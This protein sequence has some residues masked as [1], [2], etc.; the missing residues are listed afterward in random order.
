MHTLERTLYA[1][2]EARHQAARKSA[3][4][5]VN[6]QGGK[7]VYKLLMR[8]PSGPKIA[9]VGDDKADGGEPVTV[10]LSNFITL[11]GEGGN[12]PTATW[13]ASASPDED[14]DDTGGHGSDNMTR[15]VL[16]VRNSRILETM[17][18]RSVP[19]RMHQKGR[20][21]SRRRS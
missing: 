4:R 5:V 8:H 14:S 2:A 18:Y 21:F 1:Y 15:E 11:L 17:I 16:S 9:I 19:R 6:G 12:I 3:S 7:S 20:A 10:N 13:D